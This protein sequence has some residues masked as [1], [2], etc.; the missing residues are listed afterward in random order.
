ME[1]WLEVFH[2]EI[3]LADPNLEYDD[4]MKKSSRMGEL[5]ELI[6]EKSFRWLELDEQMG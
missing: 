2:Q 3:D 6:D 1:Q 5:I 4:M